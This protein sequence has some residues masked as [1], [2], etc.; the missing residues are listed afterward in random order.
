MQAKFLDIFFDLGF[1]S[2]FCHQVFIPV[3]F[4]Q[5]FV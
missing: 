2:F 5:Y 3:I 1:L 4:Y